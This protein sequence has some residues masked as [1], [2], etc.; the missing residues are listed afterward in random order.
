MKAPIHIGLIGCGNIGSVHAG[1]IQGSGIGLLT[2]VYDVD[3]ARAQALATR[4]RAHACQS[5]S[6]LLARDDIHA[7][8]IATPTALHADTAIRA[9]AAGKAI[10]LEKPMCLTSV[11]CERVLAAVRGHG[12]SLM[13]GQ[14]LRY[15]EPFRSIL[16]W[17]R[18]GWLGKA[19]HV[20]I[21]RMEKD[22]LN[23]ADWKRSRAM[24]GG[25]LYEVSC[26]EF[27]FLRV[28][29]GEPIQVEAELHKAA[30]ATHEI[31]DSVGVSMQYAS[32]AIAQY[33][34][35]TGFPRTEYGFCL[36]FE[37][38]MLES[39]DGFDPL[40]LRATP[41]PGST[42]SMLPFEREDPYYAEIRAWLEC[43]L[44][45]KPMP[46]TGQ[47]AATTVA[48]IEKIYRLIRRP[49]DPS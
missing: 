29:I 14:V 44:Q 28:L 6:E 8:L 38:V 30:G 16:E 9:A 39:S 4:Y 3:P 5:E 11:D 20:H 45:D 27:D 21:W 37:K 34:G 46:V 33:I 22:F 26:H 17:S 7:V 23:I 24:S 41:A 10:F 15:F 48:L 36:R 32:G 40:A 18:A 2:A 47:D 12:V 1:A 49:P 25:F 13:V 31:E 35:G 42:F 43:L 19:L